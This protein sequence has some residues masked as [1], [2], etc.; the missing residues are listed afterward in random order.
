MSPDSTS[1][2]H[3]HGTDAGWDL[4]SGPGFL[5]LV[6]LHL[7]T[8]WIEL[9]VGWVVLGG[10]AILL[11][12]SA[13]LHAAS[14]IDPADPSVAWLAVAWL[15]IPLHFL[16]I[17]VAFLWPDG[18]WRE[19]PPGGRLVLDALPVGR[20]AH[21]MA[22][23][24]AG[25]GLP[26][27]MAFSVLLTAVFLD[28]DPLFG[29]VV[30]WV[31]GASGSPAGILAGLLSLTAAYLLGSALAIRFGRV[32][33]PLSLLVGGL[34]ILLLIVDGAGWVAGEMALQRW[35]FVGHWAP[36]RTLVLAASA[37]SAD[38]APAL[39]WCLIFLGLC[40]WWAGRHDRA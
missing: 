8:L 26:L 17:A 6:R 22:R 19:V 32:I 15:L 40:I 23:V 1:P 2:A 38:L 29:A 18:V 25:L 20:R 30:A 3:P 24:T 9:P 13:A 37:G 7:R 4:P 14:N 21:R 10:L 35:L 5:A 36:G 39:L 27:V 16:T 28:S 33:L 34:V 31:G 12:V 11:P